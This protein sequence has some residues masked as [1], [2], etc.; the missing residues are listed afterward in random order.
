MKLVTVVRKEER[1]IEKQI[2]KLAARLNAVRRAAA[3]LN[4]TGGATRRVKRKKV[5]AA[6]R[7]KMSEAAK[8]RWAKR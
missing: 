4:G 8:K 3:L 2:K 7:K 5:S 1:E 6:A